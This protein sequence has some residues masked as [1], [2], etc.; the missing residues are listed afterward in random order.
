MSLP[1]Q[2]PLSVSIYLN[3]SLSK[4]NIL[5]IIDCVTGGIRIG[6]FKDRIQSR[7]A[8]Y[9]IDKNDEYSKGRI[10]Q[11]GDK[12]FVYYPFIVGVDP[13]PNVID[14]WEYIGEIRLIMLEIK[15]LDA[16]ARIVPA[17]DFEDDL[18]M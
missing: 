14:K 1:D 5:G 12:E 3:T 7:H 17:C 13:L 6:R 11:G 15:K 4:D 9:C 8:K 16:L 2:D 10:R 18:S